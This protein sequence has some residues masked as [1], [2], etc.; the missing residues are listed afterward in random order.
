MM[1]TNE[2]YFEDYYFDEHDPTDNELKSCL[3]CAYDPLQW[4]DVPSHKNFRCVSSG[5]KIKAWNNAIEEFAFI[6]GNFYEIC[7][8][9]RP[10]K[11]GKCI[12]MSEKYDKPTDKDLINI[13]Y[14]KR[15]AIYR[16]FD[17]ELH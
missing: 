2:E 12:T 13:Y 6:R 17:D 3:D 9:P 4:K 7:K 16:V 1:E 8:K 5:G 14:G 10:N 11:Y 15:S